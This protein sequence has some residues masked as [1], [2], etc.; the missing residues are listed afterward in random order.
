MNLHASIAAILAKHVGYARKIDCDET[1]DVLND[2]I[3]DFVELFETDGASFDAET[4]IE[5][6]QNRG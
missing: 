4:F 3:K 1:S 5:T 6:C 2:L